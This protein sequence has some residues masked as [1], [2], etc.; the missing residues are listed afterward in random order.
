[1][2]I[3]RR[4][5]ALVSSLVF[6]GASLY[7]QQAPDRS[8]PPR[9]GPPPALRLPPIEKRQLRSGLPVWIAPVHKVP[10]V[11]LTLVVRA[12]AMD[13]PP[14]KFGLAS[15]T[16]DMLDE[17][18]GARSALEIADAIDYLGAQLSTSATY[19]ATYIDLHVPVVRLDEALPVVA[20][21]VQR[22]TF[23]E[24][25]LKR[26][27]QERETSLVQAADDPGALASLAFPRIV[28]GTHRYGTSLVGT[29][30]S[31][32]AFT[33]DDL[34]RFH[35]SRYSPANAALMV[36]GDVK[37]DE[38]ISLLERTFGAWAGKPVTLQTANRPPP[39]LTTRKVFLIDKPGAAQSQIRIGWVGVPRSTKDYFALSVLNTILG[40]S[41]TSR[42]NANLREA[43]GYA[44][45]AGSVFEMRLGPG[46][47][48]ADAGVQTDKTTE[49]LKEFFNELTR[50][51]QPVGT[52]ELE[53]AKRYL[54][55]LLPRRFETTRGMA[56]SFAQ[57]FIYDLPAD[58][59]TTYAS[60]VSAVSAAGVKLAADEYIQPDRFDV[61]IIGDRARIEAG[62]R[63]LNLGPLSIVTAAE[64]LK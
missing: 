60:R 61:V 52:D 35:A 21:V 5:V 26:V 18:A 6:V 23:P 14:G 48:Y 51:H 13:E 4:A 50:I 31:L 2:T 28:Y 17:G 55:L 9:I 39:Q 42:L 38:V 33:R 37:P 20:D 44:Y 27:R 25:E 7:A 8:H 11:H 3:S 16:A 15:M 54:A 58:F 30:A 59:Y 57:Q 34:V 24:S 45:G 40:G 46:P 63:S 1:M 12:N 10:V 43:H 19:D 41:F 49:A 36:A 53:K 62:V 56:A 32:R 47:F 29:V 22:P 64:L